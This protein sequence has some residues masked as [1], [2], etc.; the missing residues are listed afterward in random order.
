M[1]SFSHLLKIYV[2]SLASEAICKGRLYSVVLR[3][4]QMSTL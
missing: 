1:L 4:K 2:A 3:L